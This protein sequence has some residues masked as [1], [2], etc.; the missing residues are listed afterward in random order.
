MR[1]RKL[2]W[3]FLEL[4]LCSFCTLYCPS[5]VLDVLASEL[6]QGRMKMAESERAHQRVVHVA[7]N[8]RSPT[9]LSASWLY[10]IMLWWIRMFIFQT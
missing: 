3:F 1:W 9:V 2:H 5:C 8:F 4:T 7:L 6:L 10:F